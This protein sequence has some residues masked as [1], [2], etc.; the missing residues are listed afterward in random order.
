ML[1]RST[2]CPIPSI[3]QPNFLKAQTRIKNLLFV[4]DF[5]EREIIGAR[6]SSSLRQAGFAE[7]RGQCLELFERCRIGHSKRLH[8]AD[9]C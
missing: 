6:S 4:E 3:I 8:V 1:T 9:A 5:F 2:P 7:K